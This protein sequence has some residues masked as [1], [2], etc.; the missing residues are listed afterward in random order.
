MI[1]RRWQ[2]FLGINRT[3]MRIK[4]AISEL[5]TLPQFQSESW[6]TTIQIEMSVVFSC[7]SSSLSFEW[8]S[9]KTR[10]EPGANSNSE[11]HG[12][13]TDVQLFTK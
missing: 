4:Q 10:F 6:C 12:L 7:K 11:M 8:F 9:T 3:D 2:P 5:L 13:L 1:I